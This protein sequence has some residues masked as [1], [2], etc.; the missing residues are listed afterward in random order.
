MNYKNNLIRNNS[1]ISQAFKTMDKCFIKCLIIL[2]DK[3]VVVGTLS[4]GDLRRA[5]L[6][7]RKLDSKIEKIINK[8]YLYFY[9][10]K[11]QF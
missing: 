6:K 1:T 8:N 10:K 11:N 5:I 9:K 4:D 3:N 7:K 2:N